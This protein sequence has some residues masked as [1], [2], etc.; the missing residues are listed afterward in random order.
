MK[1]L[2][3]GAHGQLGRELVE[4]FA[5]QDTVALGHDQ[6]DVGDRD[7]VLGAV[8]TIRP[9]VVVHAAAWTN[10]D[11]CEGDPDGAW[12]VNSLGTRN[13]AR[14]AR[15]VGA[16]VCYVSSDYVFSGIA[17][18]PCTE[19]DQPDPRSVY[20]RSK[21]GGE[22]ELGPDDIVVR[23]SWLCGRH[24]GNFVKTILRLAH[25]RDEISVVDDQFGSPTFA[26][27][28][29][30]TIKRLVSDR[31]TGTF[32]VTNQGHTNW[33]DLAADTLTMAGLDAGKLRPVATADLDPPRLAPR[34]AFSVLDNAA[35]RLSG[36]PLMPDYRESLERLV[37][38]LTA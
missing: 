32:H 34:P 26:E 38:D 15:L 18:R 25:E 1:V 31:M 8:T 12:R 19:W 29:A 28:L 16:P 2:I 20:G 14:G 5:D 24:G 9:D 13:V 4:A 22:W 7:S 10:V 33:F 6:L 35:L 37:K 17:G 11:G 30:F 23:T 36:L 27:D 21:L 3:T